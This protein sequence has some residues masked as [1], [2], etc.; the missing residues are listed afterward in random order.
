[1]AE[2]FGR[3]GT[4]AIIGISIIIAA[5]IIGGMLYAVNP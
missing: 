4:A 2:Y 5:A 3:L 1:M